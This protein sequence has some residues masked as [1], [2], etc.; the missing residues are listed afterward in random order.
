MGTILCVAVDTLYSIDV[1][2]GFRLDGIGNRK[3][4]GASHEALPYCERIC[5][6]SFISHT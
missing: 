4:V 5:I 3:S 2:I 1:D 6:S